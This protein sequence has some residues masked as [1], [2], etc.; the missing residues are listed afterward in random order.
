MKIVVIVISILIAV[1]CVLLALLHNYYIHFKRNT[2]V[3]L[4]IPEFEDM[5]ATDRRINFI[6]HNDEWKHDE[7][8]ILNSLDQA[9]KSTLPDVVITE[10]SLNAQ[11][12][13]NYLFTELEIQNSLK[14]AMLFKQQGKFNKA[15]KLFEHASTIA[16]KNA[17]VLNHFGEFI[18]HMRKDIITADELYF[19]VKYEVDF[20]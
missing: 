8:E 9:L 11:Q 2:D 13:D 1:I 14:A 16:P 12:N 17:D 20:D 15:M 10:S 6:G 7:Y 18:E 3:K 19:Q 4:Y 5:I